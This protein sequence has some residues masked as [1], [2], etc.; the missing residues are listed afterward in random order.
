MFDLIIPY[1]LSLTSLVIHYELNCRPHL[2]EEEYVKLSLPG[3]IQ[4][5][6]KHPLIDD[7][8][9]NQNVL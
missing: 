9:K 2:P 7:T 3:S 6:R 5:G 1:F 8:A 4:R